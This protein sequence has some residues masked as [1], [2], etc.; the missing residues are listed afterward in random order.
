MHRRSS[1]RPGEA[2]AARWSGGCVAPLELRVIRH[3]PRFRPLNFLDS[4]VRTSK[5]ARIQLGGEAQTHLA[6]NLLL[7]LALA[8]PLSCLAFLSLLVLLGVATL[9]AVIHVLGA[10]RA[11]RSQWPSV[12]QTTLPGSYLHPLSAKGERPFAK[13]IFGSVY[14]I[15]CEMEWLRNDVRSGDSATSSKEVPLCL[16][17]IVSKICWR[18]CTDTLRRRLTR[19]RSIVVALSM[20]TCQWDLKSTAWTTRVN[21]LL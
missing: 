19:L 20:A 7:L 5:W 3:R 14:D 10:I 13:D 1:G 2:Q 18:F 21:S 8:V 16:T 9:G 11:R 4:V 17:G 12:E 6:M 15:M